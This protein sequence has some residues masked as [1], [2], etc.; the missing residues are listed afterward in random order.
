VAREDNLIPFTSDQSREEAVKNGRKGG[1]ASG[2]ARRKKKSMRQSLEEILQ[3][4]IMD[5][6]M[7]KQ[8]EAMGFS[9]D[10]ITYQTAVNVARIKQA[11][12]GNVKAIDSVD[13]M[14]DEGI[15]SKQLKEQ[16]R[17]NKV[18]EKLRSEEIKGMHGNTT[19]KDN[20]KFCDVV[21]QMQAHKNDLEEYENGNKTV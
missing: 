3:M 1:I 20:R 12:A 17:A 5:P 16:K 14:L 9:K 2:E 13:E 21:E 8:M 7:V 19:E 11:L 4:Q 15:K 6:K 10:D 18:N